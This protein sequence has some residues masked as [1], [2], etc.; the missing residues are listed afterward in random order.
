[1][2]E[3]SNVSKHYGKTYAIDN[4]SLYINEPQIYCLLGRN[5]AGKT[6][7]MKM[8]NGSIAKSSGSIL[9]NGNEVTTINMPENIRYIEAAKKQ[10][11]FK[12]SELIKLAAELDP[13]FDSE[14]AALMINKF[15]LPSNK[16][17]N[18]LSFGMKTMVTTMLSLS[19]NADIIML[20][21]PVLGFDAIIRKE[22]YDLLQMSFESHPRIIIV[23]THLID[24]IANIASQIIMIDKGRL[25]MNEDINTISEKSYKVSG[26]SEKVE[27][28]VK[29]LNVISKDIIGKYS[30]A[31][32]FDRRIAEYDEIQIENMSVETLFIKMLGEKNNE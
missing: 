5:G 14:F 6:T 18:S 22:F 7:L 1:M 20:D 16:K 29:N 8:M 21:E 19:S 28:A 3:L 10:F 24:E 9:I 13:M 26:I 2:I 31:Y 4:L 17:Y 25:I 11:N 27:A 23:S 12:I 30:T 15:G 32:V